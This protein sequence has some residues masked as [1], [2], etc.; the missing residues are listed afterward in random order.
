M[1]RTGLFALTAVVASASIASA[2]TC[3]SSTLNTTL[4]QYPVTVEGT[5]VADI[6]AATGRGICDIARINFMADEVRHSL[7]RSTLISHN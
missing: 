6:A 2:A 5:T 7:P 1:A 3:D 4:S